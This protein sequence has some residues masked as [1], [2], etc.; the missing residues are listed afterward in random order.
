MNTITNYIQFLSDQDTTNN[1][2]RDFILQYSSRMD[3]PIIHDMIMDYIRIDMYNRYNGLEHFIQHIIP[4]QVEWYLWIH[5]IF[6]NWF[7]SGLNSVE[8]SIWFSFGINNKILLYI[9]FQYLRNS[10]R[11][12]FLV[13]CDD[14]S[15]CVKLSHPR[16]LIV[17]S[18][19]AIYFFLVDNGGLDFSVGCDTILP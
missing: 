9:H 5:Y 14:M 12:G 13:S 15:R 4:P 18:C 10:T 19:Q 17:S 8:C 3:D 11:T 6:W 7:N 16:P 1:K 2:C